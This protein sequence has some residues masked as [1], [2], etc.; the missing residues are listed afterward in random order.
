M[1]EGQAGL[2]LT[3]IVVLLHNYEYYFSTKLHVLDP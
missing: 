3:A 1:N 2:I